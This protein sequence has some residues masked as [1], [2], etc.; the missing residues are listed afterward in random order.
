MSFIINILSTPA[1][2]V[3]LISLFGLILQKK[4]VEDVVKGTVK[5]IVGFLVLT[6]GSSFLQTGSLNDF[7]VIFNYAFNMQ[8]VVPNNEAIVSLGLAD[9]ASD[10]AYIMCIGMIANIVLARFSRL[11]YI[12]L[13]GHH[14]LIYVSNVSNYFKCWKS[15]RSNVMDFRW[16]DP[17]TD[18]GNFTSTLS[19]Y[20]G[21]NYGNR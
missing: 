19:A 3:G 21:K 12:F 8:G 9:F 4:P 6:A 1:I 15:N 16:T 10:T 17:W 2:L 11:H 7:G 18:H 5:T 14:T 13:T 20:Y